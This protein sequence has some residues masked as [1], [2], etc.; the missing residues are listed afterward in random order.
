LKLCKACGISKPLSKFHKK[1]NKYH[2]RC[3]DCKNAYQREHY[4]K[5]SEKVRSHRAEYRKKRFYEPYHFLLKAHQD[6]RWRCKHRDYGYCDFPAFFDFALEANFYELY[7]EWQRSGFRTE[8]VPSVDRID[9][10]KGYEIDNIQIIPWNMN[11]LKGI[12]EILR[13]NQV[14]L[15]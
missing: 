13:R 7:Q 2:C 15:P 3:A 14:I 5:H 1:G 12:Y 11:K 4:K 8:I 6:I 9:N 10:R